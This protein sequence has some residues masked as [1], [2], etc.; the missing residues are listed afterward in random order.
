MHTGRE[1]I[2]FMATGMAL[3]IL[4]AAFFFTRRNIELGKDFLDKTIQT[5]DNASSQVVSESFGEIINQPKTLPASGAYV[6]IAYNESHINAITCHICDPSGK[7]SGS[8]DE[9]CLKD[10][11]TGDIKMWA[12]L[13]SGSGGYNVYLSS[14][15]S[16]L[17]NGEK[18][19][20]PA[21]V[22][23]II[24]S[25]KHIISNVSCSICGNDYNDI[26]SFCLFDNTHAKVKSF[27][28]FTVFNNSSQKYTVYIGE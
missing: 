26:E 27:K 8:L 24:N 16:T 7:I 9:A 18:I 11:L 2:A 15:I 20:S 17:T 4:A 6:L 23:T 25:N 22:R 13:D 1:A 3:I 5:T 19:M 14:E 28:I 21:E 12:E 10:H